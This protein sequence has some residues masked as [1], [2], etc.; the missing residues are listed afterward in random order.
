VI[1]D[2]CSVFHNASK[3]EDG[4]Y[5]YS[6]GLIVEKITSIADNPLYGG[7]GNYHSAIELKKMGGIIEHCHLCV[8]CERF[9]RRDECFLCS[10][11]QRDYFCSRD[12][13][14]KLWKLHKPVCMKD[15]IALE[16]YDP[17]LSKQDQDIIDKSNKERQAWNRNQRKMIHALD[18]AERVALSIIS[19]E[20]H[21]PQTNDRYFEVRSTDSML[22]CFMRKFN[23]HGRVIFFTPGEESGI[24]VLHLI[25]R[26]DLEV[27]IK[28][29]F[30]Q[31][32]DVVCGSNKV[33]PDQFNHIDKSYAKFQARYLGLMLN[34]LSKI[35]RDEFMVAG[36]CEGFPIAIKRIR[37]CFQSP[38][39]LFMGQPLDE[40]QE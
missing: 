30:H 19:T 12:C 15:P 23:C 31:L 40:A 25:E 38:G 5:K 17:S 33:P 14:K 2:L 26:D 28:N 34:L 4:S 13:Q 10:G 35:N 37:P 9:F 24:V 22:M 20:L 11:C 7:F 8:G 29:L 32:M 18:T 36:S 21:N 6:M 16:Y 27:Y 1:R 39:L 3:N